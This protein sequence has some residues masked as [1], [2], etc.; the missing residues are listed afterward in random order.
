MRKLGRIHKL[1]VITPEGLDGGKGTDLLCLC[2]VVVLHV[3]VPHGPFVL[4]VHLG[5]Q[6]H[7]LGR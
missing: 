2:G 6:A 7:L 1:I 5:A 3:C 4:E